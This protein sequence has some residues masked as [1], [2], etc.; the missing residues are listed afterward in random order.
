VDSNA[1]ARAL[2]EE[3]IAG[4]GVDVA[5]QEPA[6]PDHPFYQCPNLIMTCHSAGFSPDRQVRLV[7]LLAENVRRYS[8]GLPLLNVVDKRRG[9]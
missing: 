4:A 8:S 9:Y 6:S 1:L 3:W 7:A 5:D 2:K